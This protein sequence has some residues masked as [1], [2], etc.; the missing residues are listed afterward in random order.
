MKNYEKPVV[1]PNDETAE[2]VYAASGAVDSG[3]DTVAVSDIELVTPGN[4]YY[5]T[6]V[7][8][9]TICNYS[10]EEKK[11]WSVNIKVVS[12]NATE[13]KTYNGW[14]ARVSL[15]GNTVTI[16]PSDGGALDAGKAISVEVVI[17]YDSGSITVE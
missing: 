14:L 15:S 7:Y 13:A 8:R 11:D 3:V 2:G 1:V 10:N 5:K 4:E 12:G 6:N 9:V 17:S 16:T